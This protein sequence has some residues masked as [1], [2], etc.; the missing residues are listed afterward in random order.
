MREME[1]DAL[2][3]LTAADLHALSTAPN[4]PAAPVGSPAA[5]SAVSGWSADS[6][7]G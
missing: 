6:A 3:R 5:Q 7:D 4:S 2:T 1:D